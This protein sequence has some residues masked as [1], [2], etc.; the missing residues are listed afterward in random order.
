VDHVGNRH[1]SAR[2]AALDVPY[3]MPSRQVILKG[4]LQVRELVLR[5]L[6][7]VL[8]KVPYPVRIGRLNLLQGARFGHRYEANLIGG[9]SGTVA[10]LSDLILNLRQLGCYGILGLLAH[11]A[12]YCVLDRRK[13]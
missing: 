12:P 10:S 8:P 9:P 6:H 3:E 11:L 2:L 4:W 7:A 5:F 13:M 1:S